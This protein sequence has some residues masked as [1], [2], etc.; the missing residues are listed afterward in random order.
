MTHII[1]FK[2][3]RFLLFSVTAIVLAGEFS[4]ISAAAEQAVSDDLWSRTRRVFT[5][6]APH[7]ARYP[8]MAR[9]SE[10]ELVIL[11]TAVN[12]EQENAGVGELMSLRSSDDGQTWSDP[13]PVYTG[14]N[15]EPRSMGS[16]IQLPSGELMAV[17][18]EMRKRPQPESVCVI[19]SKNG[20]V[21]WE[22]CDAF[23]FPDVQWGCPHGPII[24]AHDGTLLMPFYGVQDAGEESKM[25]C[26][27][28]R[29]ADGGQSWTDVT[30][31]AA[32]E[33]QDFTHPTLLAQAGESLIAIIASGSVLYRCESRDGGRHWSV[34]RQT[35]VGREPQLVGIDSTAFACLSSNG[36]SWGF[37]SATFSYNGAE[38]WRCDRKVMEHPGEPG[39]HYG[40]ATGLALDSKNL[41]V[42]FGR[43]QRPV[44]SQDGPLAPAPASSEAERIEVVFFERD[45][46]SPEPVS[47]FQ[48]IPPEARDS[49]QSVGSLTNSDFPHQF[50]R[51]ADGQ[52]VGAFEEGDSLLRV[53]GDGRA[54]KYIS[55]PVS[56][57]KKLRGSSDEGVTWKAESMNLPPQ[58]RG[59][60]G[61]ITRLST[62][63][64]LLTITEW[65]LVEWDYKNHV[66]IDHRNGYAVW[67]P[68]SQAFHHNR[69]A[70]IYSDDNGKTWQGTDQNIDFSPFQWAIPN[71]PFIE[72]ADGVVVLPIWGCMNAE[73]GFQRLDSNGLIR[74]TD[75]GKTW[76]N[77]SII[78]YDKEHRRSCYNEG[79]IAVMDDDVW[80]IFMRTEYRDVG[81]E[82]A[83]MSRSVSTDGG[84]TWSSPELCFIGGVPVVVALPDGGIAVGASGGLHFTYDLGRTWTRVSP[85]GG[86]VNPILLD[87]NT[88][89][90]GNGQNWGSFARW[91]RTPAGR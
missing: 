1:P 7:R 84:N 89:L 10:G 57:I 53:W 45:P 6:D 49:W 82:G 59:S 9:S 62:G 71:S 52:L 16:L 35:L 27:M 8:S 36:G 40:W 5:W 15:G 87:E 51:L 47:R 34:P 73:D 18:S 74:S 60:P 44:R 55:N 28:A 33:T 61:V 25:S 13:T 64:L 68:D 72:R 70:V 58:F 90:V 17:V 81:N 31:I 79:G 69:L 38:S 30:L 37:I 14:Q 75:G 24:E 39:G 22:V 66:V 23:S 85:E 4:A 20:G 21:N 12:Q 48:P 42:A 76:G 50:C 54:A 63:R 26:W 83:W 19:R 77:P 56:S 91:R 43:S 29:S 32:G 78:A 2:T 88:M 46:P 3:R 86:Y 65:Q 41:I 80:V 67:D 11:F